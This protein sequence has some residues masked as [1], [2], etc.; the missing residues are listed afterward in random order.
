MIIDGI[1]CGF[2]IFLLAISV[3]YDANGRDIEF[4]SLDVPASVSLFIMTFSLIQ[5]VIQGEILV[6]LLR[7]THPRTC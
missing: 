7:T 4:H 3:Y 2:L 5:V 6:L 1:N